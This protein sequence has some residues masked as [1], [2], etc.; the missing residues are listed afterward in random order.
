MNT[1]TETLGTERVRWYT[2]GAYVDGEGACRQWES[3]VERAARAVLE[4]IEEAVECGTPSDEAREEELE[5]GLETLA[6]E[7]EAWVRE[8]LPDTGGGTLLGDLLGVT[9][10]ATD[11][12]A[13]ARSDL[14]EA[15]DRG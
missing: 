6:A 2:G 7:L 5:D 8:G 4:A 15:V 10:A 9:L 14:E 11:W 12:E 3:M 1:N 13:I